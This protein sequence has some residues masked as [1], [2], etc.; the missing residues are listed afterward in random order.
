MNHLNCFVLEAI[1]KDLQNKLRGRLVIDCF[2][3][4]ID[5]L[6]IE[7]ED[8]THDSIIYQGQQI[9]NDELLG[10]EQKTAIFSIREKHAQYKQFTSPEFSIGDYIARRE[11][12]MLYKNISRPFLLAI[13]G[14][15]AWLVHLAGKKRKAARLNPINPTLH[16]E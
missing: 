7:F 12:S 5:D 2:S 11:T 13:F 3:N 4:S 16:P 10:K 8:L 1:A 6:C 14:L 15:L 9:M